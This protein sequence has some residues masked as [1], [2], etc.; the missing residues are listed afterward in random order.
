MVTVMKE[1]AAVITVALNYEIIFSQFFLFLL[2]VSYVY[3]RFT[4]SGDQ[5]SFIKDG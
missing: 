2:N 5:Y 3:C 4:F 1:Q